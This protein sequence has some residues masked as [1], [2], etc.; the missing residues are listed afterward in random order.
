[1]APSKN[2]QKAIDRVADLKAELKDANATLKEEVEGTPLYKAFL[3]AIKE[4][5]PD[6]VPDKVAA[7]NAFKLTLSMLTK[8][9]EAGTE[10]S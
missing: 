8:K 3:D 9:E 7:A 6:Q 4:T 5:L 1:M 10:D 2:L